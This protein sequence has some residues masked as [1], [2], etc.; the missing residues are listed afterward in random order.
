MIYD[1]LKNLQRYK[2]LSKNLDTALQYLEKTD[3]STLPLGKT[4]IDGDNVFVN[5]MEVE[6]KEKEELFYEIHREY[7]DIQLD[8]EGTELFCLGTG[9]KT[10]TKPYNAETDF[11]PCEVEHQVDCILGKGRFVICMVEE[12]HMP[13][14]A[15]S[16]ERHLKKAVFKVKYDLK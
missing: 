9:E 8:I 2:G 1:E 13:S 5:I 6:A 11:A 14:V 7:I 3:L 10:L 4:V 15:A 16:K 12:P